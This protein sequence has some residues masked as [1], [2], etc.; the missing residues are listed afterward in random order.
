MLRHVIFAAALLVPTPVLAQET[1]GPTTAPATVPTEAALKATITGIEGL[2]QVRRTEADKWE[3]AKL[4][5]VL[6]EGAEFRTGPRSAVRFEIPPG[7]TVTLDRLGTCSLLQAVQSANT[8][9]TDLGM[10]YG[11]VRYDIEAA[12]QAYES[13]IRSPGSTL[14]VRGTKV[15]LYNQAPFAPVAT[16]LTGRARFTADKKASMLGGPGSKKTV[17]DSAVSLTPAETAF[18]FTS[19]DV[20]LR[21]ARSEEEAVAIVSRPNLGVFVGSTSTVSAPTQPPVTAPEPSFGTLKGPLVFQLVWVPTTAES[22]AVDLDLLVTSPLAEQLSAKGKQRV[23]S[24]GRIPFDSRGLVGKG[25]AETAFWTSSFPRGRYT[26]SVQ[27]AE[28]GPSQYQV[29]VFRQNQLVRS[30]SGQIDGAGDRDTF[31]VR[32]RKDR[33]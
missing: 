13:V 20:A 21:G 16:S 32:F 3:P 9:K 12:G 4:G 24:G 10:R 18:N 14:A 31:S 7:Q 2:V 27:G 33:R 30:R 19:M 25:G 28:G 1:T 5:M 6:S 22:G 29:L 15:S 11:R 8:I 26:Y 23:P 17:I